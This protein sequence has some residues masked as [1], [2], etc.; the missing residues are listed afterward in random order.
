VLFPNPSTGT[1][2]LSGAINTVSDADLN[3]EV[4][5][6]VGHL[7][8]TGK[9]KSQSGY[10]REQID[11]GSNVAP[12]AYLLRVNSESVSQVFRFVISR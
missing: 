10:V 2:T 7:V 5:D 1:L 8:Y 11:L 12:G 3:I 4:Y 6:I 9:T